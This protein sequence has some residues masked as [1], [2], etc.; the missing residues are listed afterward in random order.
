MKKIVAHAPR[1][2]SEAARP[3][4]S[5]IRDAAAPVILRASPRTARLADETYS[6]A[7]NVGKILALDVDNDDVYERQREYDEADHT[8]ADTLREDPRVPG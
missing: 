2:H 7:R 8:F 3:V 6:A 4:G 1:Q 5:L